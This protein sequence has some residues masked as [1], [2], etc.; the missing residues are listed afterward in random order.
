[1]KSAGLSHNSRTGL[2]QP[3]QTLW[4]SLRSTHKLHLFV[5]RSLF[6]FR[7]SSSFGKNRANK[8]SVFQ[9][10]RRK[11]SAFIYICQRNNYFF[12]FFSAKSLV[13]AIV[14]A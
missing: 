2:L 9:G 6:S 1:M 14:M 8:M 5:G 10:T 7:C 4:I 3:L 11:D 13:S 12:P